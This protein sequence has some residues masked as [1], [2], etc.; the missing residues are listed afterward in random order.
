MRELWRRLDER[1]KR[2]ARHDKEAQWSLRRHI[3][4]SRGVIEEREFAEVVTRAKRREVMIALPH[5]NL[6]LDDHVE[7]AR[8]VSLT[9]QHVVRVDLDVLGYLGDTREISSR[10]PF[11]QRALA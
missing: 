2:F 4:S 7:L 9:A 11:E 8:G 1:P 10:Q 6:S 3:R 5:V